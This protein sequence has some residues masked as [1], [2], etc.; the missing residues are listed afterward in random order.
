[1][2]VC[3]QF[4]QFDDTY[5]RA[6]EADGYIEVM[7][8]LPSEADAKGCRVEAIVSTPRCAVCHADAGPNWLPAGPP[9][10]DGPTLLSA[11]CCACA[12]RLERDE[13]ARLALA[14]H[15]RQTLRLI[16]A[17]PEGAA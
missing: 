15:A 11:V 17:P 16:D 2:K 13:A 3:I 5:A 4:A 8:T 7:N 10:E 14:R 6:R 9:P 12:E 1:V